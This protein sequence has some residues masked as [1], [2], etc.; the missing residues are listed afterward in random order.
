MGAGTVTAGGVV[1]TTVTVKLFMPVLP[2]PSL[3]LQVTVV[4]PRAKLLPEAGEQ[5]TETNP[6]QVSL[7][8]ALKVT[9]A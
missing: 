6:A 9:V 4:A 5:L 1:S 7:A 8:L 3:A 2:C